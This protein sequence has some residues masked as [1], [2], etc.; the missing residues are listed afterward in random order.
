MKGILLIQICWIQWQL[1][2]ELCPDFTI[3]DAL[4]A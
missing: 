4:L 3:N 1:G 2:Q